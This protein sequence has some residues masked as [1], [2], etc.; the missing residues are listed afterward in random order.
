MVNIAQVK[1]FLRIDFDD[2]NALLDTLINVADKYLQGAI[3]KDYNKDD[4][5]AE[6][7]SLIIIQ[8][9]YDNRGMIEKVSGNVRKLIDDFSLQLKLETR[10]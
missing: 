3:N 9:L 10:S 6:M 4:E 7:L 2:D 8:D 5:R 1:N